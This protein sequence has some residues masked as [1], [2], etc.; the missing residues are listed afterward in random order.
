IDIE[1]RPAQ[2]LRRILVVPLGEKG[3][4]LLDALRSTHQPV[5]LRVFAQPRQNLAIHL[6]GRELIQTL[7]DLQY[8]ANRLV[9]CDWLRPFFLPSPP[10][11]FGAFTS[12]RCPWY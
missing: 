12:R 6:L 8:S 2:N 3:H 11:T 1:Q 7:V 5:A 10:A 9:H 4:R